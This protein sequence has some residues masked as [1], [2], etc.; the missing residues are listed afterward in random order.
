LSVPTSSR[1][2]ERG[3]GVDAGATG[4]KCELADGNA[5]AAGALVA[6]AEDALSVAHHDDLDAVV[7]GMGD[8]LLDHVAM[9]PAQEQPA[10]IIMVVAIF[11]AALS[12]RRCIDERQ[13]LG[14]VAGEQ[15]VEQRLV[16]VLQPRRDR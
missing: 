11:L 16:H 3:G 10:R 15:R 8:D 13:K 7:S 14:E 12:D 6:E 1:K 9:R 4:V 2:G 5:H